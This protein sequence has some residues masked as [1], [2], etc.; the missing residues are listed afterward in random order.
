MYRMIS[1]DLSRII[2]IKKKKKKKS[3]PRNYEI[4]HKRR[5]WR[6]RNGEGGGVEGKRS[7]SW[8]VAEDTLSISLLCTGVDYF[9]RG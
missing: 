8:L 2:E 9:R 3:I 5:K 7:A 1:R 6:K 4:V